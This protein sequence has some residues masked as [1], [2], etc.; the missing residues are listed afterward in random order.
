MISSTCQILLGACIDTITVNLSWLEPIW[1]GYNDHTVNNCAWSVW[2]DHQYLQYFEFSKNRHTP[3]HMWTWVGEL[4]NPHF[5]KFWQDFEDIRIS[6]IWYSSKFFSTQNE[7]NSWKFRW[8]NIEIAR[9]FEIFENIFDIL[10]SL[11]FSTEIVKSLQKPIFWK[12]KH[13]IFT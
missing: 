3:P 12:K 10:N 8:L 7:R 6:P 1:R 9:N 11:N 4:Q 13:I 5:S 2:L